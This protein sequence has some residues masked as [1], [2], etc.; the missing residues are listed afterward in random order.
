MILKRAQHG[1]IMSN[2]VRLQPFCTGLIKS[3][4]LAVK[5][6]RVFKWAFIV[7]SGI[8]PVPKRS[9]GNPAKMFWEYE[10]SLLT[11]L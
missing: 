6:L 11:Y 1:L 10:L 8:R 2:A 7:I 9:A 5:Q 4:F 3:V